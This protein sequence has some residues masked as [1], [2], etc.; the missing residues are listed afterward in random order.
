LSKIKLNIG[1]DAGE[2]VGDS[3]DMIKP[4]K[5]R[6]LAALSVSDFKERIRAMMPPAPR[7]NNQL[8]A[9]PGD[10]NYSKYGPPRGGAK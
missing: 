3:P 2:K 5:K 8:V 1:L 7:T 9:K 10:R 4:T 6:N